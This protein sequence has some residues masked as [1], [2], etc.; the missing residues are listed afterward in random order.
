MDF[1]VSI[2]FIKIWIKY[3]TKLKFY[4][5]LNC[6]CVKMFNSQDTFIITCEL[7]ILLVLVQ[8]CITT[9]SDIKQIE[10]A[11][12]K[13]QEKQEENVQTMS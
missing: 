7:F 6:V 12:L 13:K 9:Y 2:Q 11:I 1:I 8:L 4:F 3:F 10:N 5:D